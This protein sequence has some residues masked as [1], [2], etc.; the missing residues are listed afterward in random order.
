MRAFFFFPIQIFAALAYGLFALA[1]QD[2]PHALATDLINVQLPSGASW[3]LTIGQLFI[4][5]GILC[6]FIELLKSVN[7]TDSAIA[8]FSISAIVSVVFLLFFVLW[9]PFGTT[10]FFL[11][12]MMS[13][14]DFVV[15]G[16]VLVAVSR[17]TID[18]ES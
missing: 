6:L 18:R 17:R 2:V 13:L 11:I 10:E 7:P 8:E 16:F 9:K 4:L 15:G 5:G 12:T 1:A 3:E 14:L